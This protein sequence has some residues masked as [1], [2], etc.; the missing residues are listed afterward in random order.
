V[1]ETALHQGSTKTVSRAQLSRFPRKPVRNS[2]TARSSP[3]DGCA[4]NNCHN[5]RPK[6]GRWSPRV[7]HQILPRERLG[8]TALAKILLPIV[9]TIKANFRRHGRHQLKSYCNPD[10]R[11]AARMLCTPFSGCQPPTY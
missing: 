4:S 2:S 3:A 11:Q 6:A 9:G 1:F 10:N 7:I 8:T 5:C